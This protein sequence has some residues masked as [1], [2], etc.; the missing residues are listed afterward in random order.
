MTVALTF[1]GGLVAG[2]LVAA[3][4]HRFTSR[5]DQANRRSE[6]RI[7]FLLG[8]YRS[9]ADVSNR[10][11]QGG[12]S[13]ARAFEKAL[14][15]IQLLGSRAQAEK[16][17]EVAEVMASEGGASTDDLLKTLRNDLRAELGLSALEDPPVHL[18]IVDR[19]T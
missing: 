13:D 7:Q 9:L 16:A 6:M 8:A 10:G 14:D 2:G 1:L 12:T 5:R 19:S 3:L 4:T 18:R 11:L 17:K 15:D